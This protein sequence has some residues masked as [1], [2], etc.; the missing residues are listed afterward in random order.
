[1]LNR[2]FYLALCVLLTASFPD[3]SY[4]EY[5]GYIGAQ[6]RLFPRDA[7]D[8]NQ[9]D[10]VVSGV[11]APEWYQ[12]LNDGDDSFNIKLFYRHDDEDK[13]RRHGDIREMYWQHV[14]AD[15]E[16]TAG[17]NQI[18]WGV[19]ESQHLVDIVNQTDQVEAPD[20]EEKL[21]QPMIHLSLLRD[22]GTVDLMLLPGFRDRTF[23]GDKGRLRSEPITV[24]D[25]IYESGAAER[26]IDLAARWSHYIDNWSFALSG[27]NG[28]SREPLLEPFQR[29]NKIV[30]RPFYPQI[31]QFGAELQYI[32]GDWL[33]KVEGIHR[34]FS[35]NNLADDY[36]AITAGF[37]Y[38]YVSFMGR[39]WDLGV[40]AEYSADSRQ[41]Q[42]GVIYQNDFFVGFRLSFNDIASSEILFGTIQDLEHSD[43][44]TS[45][46]EASTRLGNATR[47]SLD[48]YHFSA[49][50]K[51][52]PLYSLRR[53]TF[54]ELNV[55]YHF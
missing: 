33:W 14:G 26:H 16:L 10:T 30:L 37:E 17:I 28:T 53:D 24:E 5:Q 46:L 29:N 42:D 47:V 52:D 9:A 32:S 12:S 27:F 55:D 49:H 35:D 41:F 50:A 18:F 36:S 39:S 7:I 23:P 44:A 6:L 11:L 4:A 48:V 54:V 40:L 3:V 34:D 2:S 38:T 45:F 13:E 20:G 21:G 8:N 15:W 25:A 51:N 31:R 1:M 22:W 19:T 43:S